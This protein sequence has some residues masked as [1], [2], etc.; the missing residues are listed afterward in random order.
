MMQEWWTEGFR[1]QET[2]SEDLHSAIDG[3][4]QWQAS[5][6]APVKKQPTL[7]EEAREKAKKTPVPFENAFAETLPWHAWLEHAHETAPEEYPTTPREW[8]CFV[9]KRGNPLEEKVC[10]VCGTKKGYETS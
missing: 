7:W 8:V 4:Q 3:W 2:P 1:R 5:E 9:C 10:S 6:V